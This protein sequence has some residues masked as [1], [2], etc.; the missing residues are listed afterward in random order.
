MAKDVKRNRLPLLD[1]PVFAMRKT[2]VKWP[3]LR[4]A[5]LTPENIASLRRSAF[6]VIFLEGKYHTRLNGDGPDEETG[7]F[8]EHLHKVDGD[9]LFLLC[10]VGNFHNGSIF[11]CAWQFPQHLNWPAR[12]LEY[13]A[14]HTYCMVAKV[15]YGNNPMDP[16]VAAFIGQ[17]KGIEPVE[18]VDDHLQV[19][20]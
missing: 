2:D 1:S 10:W 18:M 16:E 13:A 20:L 4:K 12:K 8:F 9:H 17:F 7:I 11:H 15:I 6:G 14:F 3:T 19:D 5:Y